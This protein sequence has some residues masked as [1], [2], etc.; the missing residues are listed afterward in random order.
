[1]E[2]A[3][4]KDFS[5]S[6]NVVV[7]AYLKDAESDAFKALDTVS[8]KL[9]DDFVFGYSVDPEAAKA[10]G[11]EAPK[12][13]LYKKFDE[14]K[15]ILE[16]DISAESIENLIKSEGMPLVGEIGPENYAE[17]VGR[18][19]PIGYF[20]YGTAEDKE[21]HTADLSAIAK[22]FKGK[23]SIVFIDGAKYGGHGKALNLA[24][25]EWPAFAIQYPSANTKFP[26]TGELSADGLK[27][28]VGGVLSGKI[29]PSLKS[30]PLPESND[31]PVKVIVG[32]NYEQIVNDP[33]SDVF[34]KVYAPWCGHWYV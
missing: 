6:D 31:G 24:G 4:V 14:G 9:R 21:K 1:M 11:V 20:F 3:A 27:T 29:E 32:K 17:Y 15:A 33:E 2:A 10:A 30:Q 28:F 8:G 5:A 26:Y 19:L 13:V 34:V 25:D 7:V 12:V 18:E 23:V 22:E 16:G